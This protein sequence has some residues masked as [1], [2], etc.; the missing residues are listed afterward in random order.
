MA[1]EPVDAERELWSLGHYPTVARHLMPI[2]VAT[3]D[4]AG[5]RRGDRVLDVGTG[6]GN[7]AAE[8]ARRGAVVRGIDLSPQ[9]IEHAR[10]R[11]AAEG[12]TVDLSVGDAQALEVPDGSVDVVVSVMAVI[13]APDHTR[14][15][16][17]LARVLRPAGRLAM[18]SWASGGW[19]E[20]WRERIVALLPPQPEGGPVPDEW[21]E[22]GEFARRLEAVGLS[23]VRVTEEP[24]TFRFAS[25][26]E[27]ME[28]FL[29]KAGPFVRTMATLESLGRGAEARRTFQ[30]ALEEANAATDGSLILPAP[31]LLGRATK[32]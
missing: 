23:E 32:P 31:Y 22:P 6:S 18:T 30:A 10:A 11:C 13:F 12:L 3:V 5:V 26:D 1:D 25:V 9:Q 15:A 4:A 29:T 16:A 24:F 7:A 8:A 17:E 27:G 20:G 28:T 21:S 14:A 2:A 19:S